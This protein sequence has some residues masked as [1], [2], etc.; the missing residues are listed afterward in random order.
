MILHTLKVLSV[1][2]TPL[3][4]SIATGYTASSRLEPGLAITFQISHVQFMLR[5]RI[6]NP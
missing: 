6:T 1:Y 5:M 2:H 4:V 3:A